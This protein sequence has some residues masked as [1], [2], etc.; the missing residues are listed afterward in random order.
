MLSRK[1]IS[2]FALVIAVLLW[3]SFMVSDM[4]L[5]FGNTS[6]IDSGISDKL[7]DII[8]NLF[9]IA[10]YLFYKF[11]IGR[12][13]TV[14]FTD[15]LWRIFVTGL[16]CTIISFI[17]K[18]FLL[19]LEAT[20]LA[21][22]ILLLDFVYLINLVLITVFLVSTFIVWKRLIL[23][24]K[25]KFLVRIWN[26]FEYILILSIIY[27]A[28]P[29]EIYPNLTLYYVVLLI[30]M[31]LFLSANMRWVAYLNFKQKWK[32]ILLIFLT[33]LYLGYFS[34]NL[35]GL[36]NAENQFNT[37]LWDNV[38]LLSLIAFIFIY[39][40]FSLLVILFNLP[41]SSVFEK[42]LEEVVNF[43]KLSQ[44]IQTDQ[45]EEQVYN[46]LLESSVSTVLA[47]AAWIE[48]E[49]QNDLFTEN[50]TK[51]KIDKIKSQIDENTEKGNKQIN[52]L[53]GV[54]FKSIAIF[55]INVQSQQ[56]GTLALLKEMGDGFDK[57]SANII[58][59]FVAQTEVSVENSRLINQALENER[60]KE[61]LKIA[62]EV[63]TSLLPDILNKNEQF[64][65]KAF[66]VSADEVGG[67]YYDTYQINDNLFSVIIGDVSGKGT[68]AAFHMSQMKGV[69]Q[70]LAQLGLSSK[71]FL[72]NAN[73]AISNCLEK[74]SFIT[75]SY[76]LIDTEK[77]KIEFSRAGHCPTIYYSK[78]SNK[79]RFFTNKGLGLGILRNGDFHKYIHVNRLTYQPGD[80][81]LLYTDGISEARNK[82]GEEYGYD[83]IKKV[84]DTNTNETTTIIQERLINDLYDFTGSSFINDDYTTLVIKFNN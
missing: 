40:L 35:Y 14:N 38:F 41:T 4:F 54:G 1:A 61:E 20:R 22:N 27:S 66:S 80:I 33:L 12:A 21:Q 16:I 74:T 83:R 69:F 55:P 52:R 23:Y 75:V 46:I 28:L 6:N 59:T 44:S 37:N 70:S 81:I 18:L 51:H 67:D 78:K 49:D 34:S 73:N 5:M 36:I 60:Y 31:G 43:Q 45:S 84:L 9:I 77:K 56:I 42:K 58:K 47:D 8:F 62:K 57:D 2:Q 17:L 79:A 29:F 65:I 13:E 53:K 82:N 11:R 26:T 71:K 7:P 68:S 10:I 76:F 72:I 24:Q 30:I 15:L 64:D 50:I 63:Q 25:T 19:A 39:A 48:V 3:I 32:S